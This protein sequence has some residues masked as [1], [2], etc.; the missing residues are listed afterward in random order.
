LN[1]SVALGDTSDF[2]IVIRAVQW[3]RD[4][5]DQKLRRVSGQ[6][7][8]R[9]ERYDVA[10]KSKPARVADDRRERVFRS[11]TQE[12]VELGEL[13]P[14]SLPTHPY[15]VGRVPA[16]AAM[17]EIEWRVVAGVVCSAVRGVQRPN[18]VY[19]CRDDR[20][21]AGR[22]LRLRVEEIAEQRE[23][24]LRIAIREVLHL[25]VFE[26]MSDSSDATEQQRHDDGRSI[27]LGN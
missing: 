8:V 2:L 14:L 17:Q 6:Y 12:F 4:R 15:G 25:D 3:M 18:S 1:Y 20:V 11:S 13:A 22:G 23:P 10:Y 26:R 24:H 19:G 7:G 16:P 21:V 9:I 5:S 27:G